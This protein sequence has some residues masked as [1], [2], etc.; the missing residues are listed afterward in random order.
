[1]RVSIVTALTAIMMASCGTEVDV[2]SPSSR[3]TTKTT[4]FTPAAREGQPNILIIVADD[5]G[6][7]DLGF[8][9]SDIETPNVD[10]LAAEGLVL[11][12][13]LCHADL[14]ADAICPDDRA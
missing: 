10:R 5:L 6:W 8:R 12:R 14:Y 11:N 9:G 4:D 7:A 2:K 3:I 1:M 13:F